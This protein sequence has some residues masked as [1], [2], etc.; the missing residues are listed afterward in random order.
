VVISDATHY[1]NMAIVV[2]PVLAYC[3]RLF[4][5]DHTDLDLREE[6]VRLT[7]RLDIGEIQEH[8]VG[9]LSASG[10]LDDEVFTRMREDRRREFV[11]APCRLAVHAGGAYP[12]DPAELRAAIARWLDGAVRPLPNLAGIA[13]PHVSPEGGWQSYGAAYGALGVELKD[14]TFVILAT[15]HSGEPN[16][17]G[18]TRKPFATPLGQTRADARL[19]EELA[20]AGG[21][22][23]EMEDFCHS[24]EHTVEL[25]VIFLQHLFGPDVRILPILCGSFAQSL[26]GGGSPEDD[27]AVARFLDALRAMAA[28]EG[29][30]LF[31]VLG[32]DL[33]HMGSRYQDD[34]P[35]VA[36]QGVMRDVYERDQARLERVLG[37]DPEGYWELIR[38][39]HDDLKWCGSAPLYTFLRAVPRARGE[40]LHYQQWNI[41]PESVVT[42]AGIAFRG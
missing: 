29:E 33:A 4:D 36:G 27:P 41:D 39:N 16:R 37:G 38:Q 28:R 18:L 1:S 13:A 14:R 20:A 6:L 34:F 40:L 10:F 25:Q 23:V 17:F 32:I 31:W 12:N 5:G 2:P 11:E 7:G 3:L 26:Y 19:V 42:F 8:L 22:A 24:F 9:T 30:R 15:S 35:C 21:E